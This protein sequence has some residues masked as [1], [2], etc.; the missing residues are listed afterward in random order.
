MSILIYLLLFTFMHNADETAEFQFC[1][2]GLYWQSWNSVIPDSLNWQS[3]LNR[4]FYAQCGWN[5]NVQFATMRCR[6]MTNICQ[7]TTNI[8]QCTTNICQ[9]TTNICH[10]VNPTLQCTT[11]ICQC[12]TNICHCVNQTLQCTTNICQ[13]V[14]PTLQCTTNICHCTTN[15]CQCTTNICQCTINICQCT[16]TRCQC[17]TQRRN[18][19]MPSAVM[20][21]GDNILHAS[22]WNPRTFNKQ[23]FSISYWI[24]SLRSCW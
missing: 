20:S 11:N 5:R 12:T 7:C 14:N 22:A 23:I 15:I 21:S 13:C 24:A 16:T 6:C 17:S 10:C 3:L 19:G 8:C 18:I 1:W 2:N 4:P 9:C